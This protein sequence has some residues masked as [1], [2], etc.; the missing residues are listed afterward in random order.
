MR[1]FSC[2]DR[3][4]D[5]VIGLDKTNSYSVVTEKEGAQDRGSLSRQ[6]SYTGK[7]KMDPQG[8]GCRRNYEIRC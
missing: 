8:L 4:F 3:E 2:R 5:D 1:E 6:T 7:K